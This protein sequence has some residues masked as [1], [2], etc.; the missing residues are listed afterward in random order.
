MFVHY[1]TYAC[2][3]WIITNKTIHKIR[4]FQRDIERSYIRVK[5]KDK[6]N[7]L[8]IRDKT[9][10]LDAVKCIL[11]IKWHWT[12][13]VQRATDDRWSK[14]I[15]NWYPIN[16]KNVNKADITKDGVMT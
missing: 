8:K 3:T 16:K 7:H 1:L 9:K 5:L 4:T 12:G 13:H 15:T 6:I 10:A 14:I 11:K 2:Q